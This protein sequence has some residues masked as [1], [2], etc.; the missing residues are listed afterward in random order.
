MLICI[1]SREL[2]YLYASLLVDNAKLPKEL[3]VR[4]RSYLY[5]SVR[6]EYRVLFESNSITVDLLCSFVDVVCA[7]NVSVSSE[8][9][10]Y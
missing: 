10:C 2:T 4:L 7:L 5:F 6:Y 3:I 9:R 1:V 8:I